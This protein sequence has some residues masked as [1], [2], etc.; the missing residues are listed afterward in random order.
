VPNRLKRSHFNHVAVF[1][2]GIFFDAEGPHTKAWLAEH[3]SAFGAVVLDRQRLF[4]KMGLSDRMPLY[5][6]QEF[7]KSARSRLSRAA[8]TQ[9][10]S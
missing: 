3:Y 2:N 10:S 4:S 7:Y 9:F 1:Y 8:E 6:D 5:Y